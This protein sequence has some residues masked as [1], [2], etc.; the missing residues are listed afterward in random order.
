MDNVYALTLTLLTGDR[1]P[2][3]PGWYIVGVINESGKTGENIRKKISIS[4]A[5]ELGRAYEDAF[6]TN[7]E[8]HPFQVVAKGTEAAREI[9]QNELEEVER[10]ATR[11]GSLR[12]ALGEF[13]G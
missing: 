2:E 10:A 3:G 9:I 13:G 11:V 8:Q 4:D 12:K 1:A 5:Q 7:P 6:P